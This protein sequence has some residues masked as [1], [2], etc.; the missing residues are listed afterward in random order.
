MSKVSKVFQYSAVIYVALVIL[1][2]AT[3][4]CEKA[5]L[6]HLNFLKGIEGRLAQFRNT[7]ENSTLEFKQGITFYRK[8]TKIMPENAVL[9]GNIGYCYFYLGDY[10]NALSQYKKAVEI[11]PTLYTA[12]FDLGIIDLVLGS[13]KEAQFYFRKALSFLPLMKTYYLFLAE[14]LKEQNDSKSLAVLSLLIQQAAGDQK[15]MLEKL[16]K[17]DESREDAMKALHFFTVE[18]SRLFGGLAYAAGK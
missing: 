14:R 11:E 16:A 8:M 2:M 4:D 10:K 9:R 5:T 12:Y 18:E 13:Q 17:R 7:H 15:I 6:A 3:V 1:F